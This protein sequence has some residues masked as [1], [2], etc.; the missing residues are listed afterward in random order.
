MTFSPFGAKTYTLNSSISSTATSI[1]LSSFTEP[2]TG[3]PY[4]MVLLNTDIVY[5]T[6]APKTTSSEFISF[7]GIVQNADGT[8]TLTGVTRGLAKK[9]P[10][11]S[12]SAYKLPHSGQSTFIISNPPQLYNE[13]VTLDNDETIVGEKVFPGGGNANAPKSGTVYA[14]PTDDLEYSSKKYVDDT[15]SFGAPL[16]SLTVAGIVEEGTASEINAGTQVGGTTAELFV[17]PKYLKDSEYYTLRPTATEKEALAGT[18]GTPSTSNK[19]V[20]NDDTATTATANKVAR[21][22]AGG[23]ITVVTETQGNNSTNAASTA[24]VDTAIPNTNFLAGVGGATTVKSYTNYQYPFIISSDVPT[25]NFWT[26]VAT[27]ITSHI[28]FIR[29]GAT[30]DA[31]NSILTTNSV[32]AIVSG[33][34]AVDLQFSSGKAVIVEFTVQRNAVGTEQM[35]WGLVES[36]APFIDYDDA[37]VDGACFTVDAAGALYGHTSSGGGT[38]LHTETLITGVTLTNNN[39]YRIE[40]DPGVDVKFYVNGVLKAT[41]TTNLPSSAENIRFG[42]GCQ[43]NTN[44]NDRAVISAPWIAIEK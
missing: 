42:M 17:N 8:A 18:S 1:T 26:V 25:G 43:G 5:G 2:V 15:A 37:S 20:T 12:S 16:A 4:T 39:T 6:I 29:I 27:N 11:T 10:F 13:Y 19:Y 7:T 32:G 41:N 9:S 33:G 38:T 34:S 30:G 40:F 21:R 14:A 28:G 36:N 31:T 22:L 35:G 23:N 24:Y 3:T 44:D